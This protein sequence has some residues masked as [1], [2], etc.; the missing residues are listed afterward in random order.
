MALQQFSQDSAP[1]R[2]ERAASL[3]RFRWDES[4]R[5]FDADLAILTV[6]AGMERQEGISR[7]ILRDC[8]AYL[9]IWKRTTVFVAI[10][11]KAEGEAQ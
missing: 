8:L 10:H 4:I 9:S 11:R 6:L 1:R 2:R 3:I 5:N 7:R